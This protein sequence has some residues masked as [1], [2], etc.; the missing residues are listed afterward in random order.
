MNI[1]QRTKIANDQRIKI[2]EDKYLE[3]KEKK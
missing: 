3:E 1:R 2:G